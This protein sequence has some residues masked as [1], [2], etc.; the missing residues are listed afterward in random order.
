M[1]SLYAR[2]VT[3]EQS[4]GI[5]LNSQSLEIVVKD[6]YCGYTIKG[7]E[8]AANS[9][10]ARIRNEWSKCMCVCVHFTLF[11]ILLEKY[12]PQALT[13]KYKLTELI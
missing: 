4:L 3:A 9:I 10:S 12:R 2:Q 6:L 13:S 8:G 5:E 1:V 7:G 11:H